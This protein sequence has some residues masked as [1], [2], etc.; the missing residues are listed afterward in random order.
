[1]TSITT[2]RQHQI[3]YFMKKD[4]QKSAE[5]R[6]KTFSAIC[7][8]L[9]GRRVELTYIGE[10]L[11]Y[12]AIF[13]LTDQIILQPILKNDPTTLKSSTFPIIYRKKKPLPNIQC[14]DHF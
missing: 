2:S 10:T 9:A 8:S 14:S 4:Q 13:S 11:P 5:K 1:M 3:E 6:G 7:Q 12:W